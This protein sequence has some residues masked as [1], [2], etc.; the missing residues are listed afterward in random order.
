MRATCAFL[1]ATLA[2]ASA[3]AA[4]IWPGTAIF[5]TPTFRDTHP[6]S[7]STEGLKYQRYFRNTRPVL[8]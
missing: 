2:T 1:F 7:G 6:E 4:D 8:G 3:V 5:G